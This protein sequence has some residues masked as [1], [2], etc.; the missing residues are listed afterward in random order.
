MQI[1]EEGRLGKQGKS[2]ESIRD[3]VGKNCHRYYAAQL[4]MRLG[5]WTWRNEERGEDV[6]LAYLFPWKQVTPGIG[7]GI[8]QQAGKGVWMGRAV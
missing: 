3:E 1:M 6:P 2:V 8:N 5:D 4:G 7:A